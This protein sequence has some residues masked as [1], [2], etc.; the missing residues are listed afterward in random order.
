VETL[1][2]R[3]VLAVTW[4]QQQ[5]QA[6]QQHPTAAAAARVPAT[7]LQELTHLSDSYKARV[8]ALDGLCQAARNPFMPANP[9]ADAA[10]FQGVLQA[11]AEGWLP[12]A[13]QQLGSKAWAA[14]PQKYGCN[15]D[16]C[17]KLDCL[18]E[19]S[20]ARSQCNGCKVRCTHVWGGIRVVDCR[21]GVLGL[22]HC[23][24]QQSSVCVPSN[25]GCSATADKV[26]HTLALLDSN[27]A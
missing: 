18:T 4:L 1:V 23:S 3:P 5:L 6:L 9:A 21:T 26:R 11:C 22:V 19:H 20:C 2:H 24:T 17:L 12:Q 13:L 27:N 7:L 14:W 25:A 10:A 16:L 8:D 15:D